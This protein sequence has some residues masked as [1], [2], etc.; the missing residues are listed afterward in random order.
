M[1][2]SNKN[3]TY[4]ISFRSKK[5]RIM[6][7]NFP[8]QKL[9]A[10]KIPFNDN[11]GSKYSR[12]KILSVILPQNLIYNKNTVNVLKNHS[13]EQTT[14]RTLKVNITWTI[15]NNNTLLLMLICVMSPRVKSLLTEL[16]SIQC[17]YNTKLLSLS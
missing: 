15:I 4:M 16:R 10:E 8:R 5:N 11:S 6:Q 7:Q 9:C 17:H 14:S 2:F 12:A 3:K 1:L 13:N